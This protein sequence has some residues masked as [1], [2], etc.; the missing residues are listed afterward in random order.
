MELIVK[1]NIGDVVSVVMPI[2]SI[3]MQN[4]LPSY[5]S[6][7]HIAYEI[8]IKNIWTED[9]YKAYMGEIQAVG[10]AKSAEVG[11]RVKAIVEEVDGNVASLTTTE[12]GL[13]YIIHEQGTGENAKAGDY[14]T[15]DYFGVLKENGEKFDDSFSKG[16]PFQFGL[17]QGQVIAGW[18]EG[19]TYLNK[20]SKATF[21]I[22]YT[23][24][25]G[26]AGYAT[27]PAKAELVFY[28]ELQDIATN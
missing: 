20:G 1:S 2:D 6:L 18:D 12:S 11:E 23:L 16:A 4:R 28:V 21:F 9:E 3:P 24:A 13:R 8:S 10:Q 7:T 22:P 25:Y 5:D 27:I 26:E 19:L 15:V 14:V 17:G